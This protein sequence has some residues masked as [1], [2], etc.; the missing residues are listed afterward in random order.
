MVEGDG[1]KN[2]KN[3]KNKRKF[4]SGDDKFANKK[5]DEV[6]W[7]YAEHSKCY[8]FYVI[9]PNDY[10]SV[11]SIIESKDAIF[12]E[13]RFTSIPRP[14][15][16]IQS[17]SSKI[18]EDEVEGTDDVPGPSVPRKSNRTRKAKSFGSD[19][20]LYLVEGTEIRTLPN[21]A[22]YSLLE[23]DQRSLSEAMALRLLLLIR[24]QVQI[25]LIK[26]GE[27]LS[28][29]FDMKDLGEAEV[30]LDLIVK[31]QPNKGT[32]VSQLEYSRA[33][34]CLM[35]AMISTR[36]D[37]AFVVGKLSSGYPS[38]IEVIPDASGLINM[39]GFHSS[40][41]KGLGNEAE[42]VVRNLVFDIPLWPKTDVT[43][44][45]QMCKELKNVTLYNMMFS[46]LQEAWDLALICLL[47]DRGHKLVKHSVNEARG[48]KDT[49]GSLFWGLVEKLGNVEEKAECKKLKK[50]LE[51][52]RLSNT[53][54]RMQNE[55]V[56]RDLYWTRVRAHEFYQEMIRRG[57]VFEE[58]PNEA[59]NVP[60]EDEKSPLSEPQGSP[61]DS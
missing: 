34:G 9:E 49:L 47:K 42:V 60:I 20:Q 22:Y 14:R 32:L 55:R 35:Y 4:K 21:V 46:L 40:N 13:E 51:E 7:G 61:R 59:I 57:F 6:A 48:A 58:R 5:D 37:I 41:G 31:F 53:F 12:D 2:S 29:N 56:E 1:A 23:E 11:N 39:V 17:S 50:E 25:K 28:S 18:A 16:M 27:F 15:G 44:S 36:P 38:V 24:K 30:I 19:F 10:V 45:Y 3:N 43:I 52:A 54:L 8:R 26:K 33:I